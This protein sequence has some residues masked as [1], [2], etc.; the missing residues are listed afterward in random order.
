MRNVV[1]EGER[2]ALVQGRHEVFGDQRLA[3]LNRVRTRYVATCDAD[4]WYPSDYLSQATRLLAIDGSGFYSNTVARV[5]S[6][7]PIAIEKNTTSAE[8][9][10]VTPI[11]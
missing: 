9:M 6:N 3:G 4:T 2:A 11:A 10:K 7:R 8:N 1:E 5:G